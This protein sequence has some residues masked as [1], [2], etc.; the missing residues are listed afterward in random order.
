MLTD[1]EG[2]RE[3]DSLRGVC[4]GVFVVEEIALVLIACG[5][6]MGE[7]RA[8]CCGLNALPE[9][10]GR[11]REEGFV[12]VMLGLR[13]S[14]EQ[15]SCPQAHDSVGSSPL[16]SIGVGSMRLSGDWCRLATPGVLRNQIS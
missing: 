8:D 4:S 6:I 9:E 12:S 13:G 7:R 16:H 5:L 2:F 1:G 3:E 15:Q 10:P 11:E 14:Y